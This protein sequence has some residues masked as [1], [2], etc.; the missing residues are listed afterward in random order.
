MQHGL[1]LSQ[2]PDK[3]IDSK[4]L[5]QDSRM[6]LFP[7]RKD[8][9]YKLTVRQEFTMSKKFKWQS[10]SEESQISKRPN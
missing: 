2:I 5:D 9:K 4:R 8:P 1:G 6:I 7:N 10:T 3:K